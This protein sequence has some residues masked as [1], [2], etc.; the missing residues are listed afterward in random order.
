[1]L[2][3]SGCLK[4]ISWNKGIDMQAKLIVAVAVAVALSGCASQKNWGASGGSKADGTVKLA[5]T[6][7]MFERP[8]VSDSQAITIATKRCKSWG[9]KKAIAFDF[10]NEKCQQMTQSGCARTIVTK[11]FQCE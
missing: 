9:Y 7:G 1:M 6:H 3:F 10:V 2:N 5:Y 8:E 11:E 4:Q